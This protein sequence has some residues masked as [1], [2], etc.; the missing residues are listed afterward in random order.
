M[1]RTILSFGML[2][3]LFLTGCTFSRAVVNPHHATHDT[4]WIVPGVTTRADVVARFGMPPTVIKGRGGVK[5]D[6]MRWVTGDEFTGRFEA[7]YI[8]TP[9]FEL[10]RENHRHD[11]LI[12]FDSRDVVSLVSRTETVDGRNRVIE[13]REAP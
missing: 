6:S 3:A 11:L 7:G 9:T 13:F 8:V 12:K 5:G 4:S 2:S 10:S 1:M